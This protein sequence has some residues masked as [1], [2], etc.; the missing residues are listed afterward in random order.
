MP[1]SPKLRFALRFGLAKWNFAKAAFPATAWERG[2][3]SGPRLSS[4]SALPRFCRLKSSLRRAAAQAE[5]REH[6]AEH[7][8]DPAGFVDG[9]N[10]YAYVRQNPWSK[11]D[12]EGLSAFSDL[13]DSAA[14]DLANGSNVSGFAKAGVAALWEAFSFGSAS[15]NGGVGDACEAGEISGSEALAQGAANTAIAVMDGALTYGTGGVIGKA[16]QAYARAEAAVETAEAIVAGDARGAARSALGVSSGR[17]GANPSGKSA[18]VAGGEARAAA[19][20]AA[21]KTAHKNSL[22]YVGETHK[23]GE[24]A[25]GT[26]VGDGASIR[27]EQQARALRKETGDNYETEI[28][29]TFPDNASA[30][31]YETRVIERFRRMYGDDALPG[32]KTNR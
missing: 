1:I 9:P 23:I 21:E 7:E 5:E 12:P 2:C 3:E 14:D 26:R 4:V 15:K 6:S 17:K 11:F 31:G 25:Q 29:K 32:N 19:G 30:R 20:V 18:M 24:S 8:R 28:R 13:T 10:L 27:A 16:A 22:D